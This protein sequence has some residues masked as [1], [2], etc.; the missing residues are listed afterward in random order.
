[1]LRPIPR[2]I[3]SHC[4]T[5]QVCIGK[6]AWQEYDWQEYSV[7]HVHMQASNEVKKTKENTE[8]VLRS[9]LFADTRYSSPGLEWEALQEKSLKSGS[10]M[11]VLCRHQS[12]QVVT[13]EPVPDDD[14]RL[15]HYEVGLV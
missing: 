2:R 3:L 1:M 12:Y 4:V 13:V 10:P 6:N 5:L 9:V 8:V 11:R 15:H 7:S 14:G